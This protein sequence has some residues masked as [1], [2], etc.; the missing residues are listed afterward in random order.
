MVFSVEKENYNISVKQEF[1]APL[2]KVWTGL[3]R[4]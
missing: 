4:Q 3:N 2:E 1:A